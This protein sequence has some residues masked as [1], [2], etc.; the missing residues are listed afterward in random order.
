ML[1]GHLTTSVLVETCVLHI[2]MVEKN[3]SGGQRRTLVHKD[4]PNTDPKNL[5]GMPLASD[6][7]GLILAGMRA[8][9]AQTL[10]SWRYIN[11]C[12]AQAHVVGVLYLSKSITCICLIVSAVFVKECQLYLSKDINCI[13]LTTILRILLIPPAQTLCLWCYIN[14]CH[15]Q[16]QGLRM[17]FEW[18]WRLSYIHRQL[19]LPVAF[20][21]CLLY[22]F[23]H[24]RQTCH[25]SMDLID[26][27]GSAVCMI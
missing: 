18:T 26:W 14:P 24:I 17:C 4:F 3:P 15:A 23:A 25:N 5:V 20:G 7:G 13:F 2:C 27:A 1:H 11:P 6:V 16:V 12:R 21:Y 10:C 9:T 19:C 8:S 22:I